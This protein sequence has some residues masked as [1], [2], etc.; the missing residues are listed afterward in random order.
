[1]HEDLLGIFNSP[2]SSI[3]ISSPQTR[4]EGAGAQ[5]PLTACTSEWS[6]RLPGITYLIASGCGPL[7]RQRATCQG[8]VR[9]GEGR[10][11]DTGAQ[12]APQSRREGT[13]PAGRPAQAGKSNPGQIASYIGS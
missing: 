6:R 10:W 8:S 3:I 13:G 12:A 11:R 1:M 2:T 4:G 5:G 7:S 9:E